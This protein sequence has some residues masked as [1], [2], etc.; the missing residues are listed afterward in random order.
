[1]IC[2][3]HVD[4]R[5]VSKVF[6]KEEFSFIGQS[7]YG[8]HKLFVGKVV[9]SK[10]RGSYIPTNSM[11]SDNDYSNLIHNIETGAY[12]DSGKT[13]LVTWLVKVMTS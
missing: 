4:S 13:N 7:W 12:I 10:T 6:S 3:C 1:M 11:K 8:V 5:K 2:T 9:D